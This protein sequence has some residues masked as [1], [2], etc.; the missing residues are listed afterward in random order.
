MNGC[1]GRFWSVAG[2]LM[3]GLCL[4]ALLGAGVGCETAQKP[5][6]EKTGV[7]GSY[8]FWPFGNIEPRVQYVRTYATAFDLTNKKQSAFD[9][10]VFGD[11]NTPATAINKPYGVEAK[12][13][14]IYVCDIRRPGLTVLDLKK[15]QMRLVGVTGMSRLRNPVDVAVAD[16]G[17]I[18]V[19]D[20]SAKM[21]FV[22]DRNERYSRTIGHEKFEPVGV[23]VFGDRL[24]VCDKESQKVEIFNRLTGESIKVFGEVGDG[25]GQFRL[26]LGIDMDRQGNVYV[27]DMMRCRVQKFDPE[28]NYLAGVGQIGDAPGTFARPKQIAVDDDG[29]LYVVDS[30]FQ[31]VQMFNSDFQLLMEFGAAGNFAGAMNLPVGICADD[32]TIQYLKAYLH[33]G[34]N[35]KRAIIVTN[36]FGDQI[37]NVYALGERNEQYTLADL[38]DRRVAIS[39]GTGRN[40]V[41]AELQSQGDQ[42]EPLPEPAPGEEGGGPPDGSGGGGGG[43]APSAA[44][45]SATGTT[46]SRTRRS[47]RPGGAAPRGFRQPGMSRGRG[48]VWGSL[49]A[50]LA[51]LVWSGC[52]IEK[53]YELLSFFFDG[54]PNPNALPIMAAAGNPAFIRQS[55][56]Y[57][58]H[59]PYLDDRCVDCHGSGFTTGGVTAAVCMKCHGEVPQEYPRMHGP[60]PAGACLWCHVPHESAWAHLLKAPSR[61]VCGQCHDSTL[62][63]SSKV[64][65]HQDEARQCLDCH[66]G[67]GGT[68]AYFLRSASDRVEPKAKE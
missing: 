29:I 61:D 31:N 65:E 3:L 68:S 19:A 20:N 64:P 27:C 33:P 1:R 39:E 42:P 23:A 58:G 25:D 60:V 14:R 11:E 38:L 28:G 55:P 52:S 41:M 40:P 17:E 47:G 66:Y 59:R 24:Y 12:D 7:S 54:V 36:Q 8:A 53:N 10:A 9:K 18:Y 4:S 46:A 35:A 15:K 32:A 21:V 34:F 13:G 48:W 45:P 22:Y 49:C 43:G 56:T 57:S 62:L 63:S 67:H 5:K 6:T 26:P 16:D 2:R 50:G 51:G 37:V 30:A 44:L